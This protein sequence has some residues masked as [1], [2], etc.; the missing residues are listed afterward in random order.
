MRETTAVLRTARLTQID[1]LP[2]QT[3]DLS[4]FDYAP[5]Q[6]ALLEQIRTND[7]HNDSPTTM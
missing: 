2:N 1:D 3:G 6:R 7:I 4:G 5:T